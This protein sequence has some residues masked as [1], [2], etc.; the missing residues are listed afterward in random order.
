MADVYTKGLAAH[1]YGRAL[2]HPAS[3]KELRPGT[4]GFFNAEGLWNPIAHL[5]DSE[6]LARHGLRFPTQSLTA[7]KPERIS[8]WFPKTS[9]DVKERVGG[10]DL[11]VE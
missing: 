8:Q 1:P 11:G 6:S 3:T 9:R 5:E 7:A 4:V 2:Y 10:I